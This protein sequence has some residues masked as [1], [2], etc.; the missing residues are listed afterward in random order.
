M[1]AR[2]EQE[3]G[4]RKQ[5]AVPSCGAESSQRSGRGLRAKRAGV[6]GAHQRQECR[7][8]DFTHNCCLQ[9]TSHKA[10]PSNQLLVRCVPDRLV[11]QPSDLANA[12]LRVLL[13]ETTPS[14]PPPLRFTPW[15]RSKLLLRIGSA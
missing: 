4:S 2:R 3:A 5:E 12:L 11:M 7:Q 9:T 10:V 1:I 15:E 14:Q 13:L 8:L 6:G